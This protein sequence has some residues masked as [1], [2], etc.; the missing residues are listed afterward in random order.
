MNDVINFD[1]G[2]NDVA[3][4]KGGAN[5]DA[6]SREL[7]MR[8]GLPGAVDIFSDDTEKAARAKLQLVRSFASNKRRPSHASAS[9]LR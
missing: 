6:R 3:Q 7:I 9:P 8:S 5:S 4:I 1:V 2:Y